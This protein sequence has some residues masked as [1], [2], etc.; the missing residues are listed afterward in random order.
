MEAARAEAD[1]GSVERR[2]PPWGRLEEVALHLVETK[3]YQDAIVFV[4]AWSRQGAPTVPARLALC[5]AFMGLRLLDRAWTRLE[6]LVEHGQGPIGSIRLATRLFILRGWSKEAHH[7]ASVGLERIPDDEML[8]HL[9]TASMRPVLRPED[10]PEPKTLAETIR[11]AEAFMAR[12]SFVKAQGLLERVR[13]RVQPKRVGRIEE[14]LWAMAGDFSTNRSLQDLCE[15]LGPEEE[16]V[17]TER[18]SAD[19]VAVA[20]PALL[21]GFRQ[22]FRDLGDGDEASDVDEPTSISRM[23]HTND[24]RGTFESDPD[25]KTDGSEST[26][27]LRVVRRT[28]A[29]IPSSVP[30]DPESES[31]PDYLAGTEYEDDNLVVMTRRQPGTRTPPPPPPVQRVLAEREREEEALNQMRA[32]L[33]RR[34]RPTTPRATPRATE[35]RKQPDSQGWSPDPNDEDMDPVWPWLMAAVVVMLGSVALIF[36]VVSLFDS[37]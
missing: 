21:D 9:R 2:I 26:E 32:E 15:N 19:E 3:Q 1:I 18:L 28:N 16:P 20:D 24:M 27:I 8:T 5:E 37:R 35:R 4:E 17:H 31:S 12:G 33:H 10:Q 6:D 36:G 23:A 13:R 25:D 22:L 29:T 30:S 14:L 34:A 11:L 7:M